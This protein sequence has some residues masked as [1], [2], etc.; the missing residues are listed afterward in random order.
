MTAHAL[1]SSIFTSLARSPRRWSLTRTLQSDNPL[2]IHG[3]LHGTA[4]FT[5]LPP[6]EDTV[7]NAHNA[8]TNKQPTEQVQM[9]YHE[10]GVMPTTAGLGPM[11]GLRWTKRYIWRQSEGRISVWFVKVQEKRKEANKDK[12]ADT[13]VEAEAEAE[14]DY[15]FHDFEVNTDANLDSS[16]FVTPPVPPPTLEQTTVIT[17]RGNHLCINDMYRTA[18]AF[19]VRPETG[20]VVSWASRHVVKGPKKNQDIVNVYTLLAG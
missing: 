7:S 17:A 1:L 18:Y 5:L 6:T 9:L 13:D 4:T 8:L 10:E 15:L 3:E 11:A 14:A 12:S 20:E 16:L 19:R 2:D